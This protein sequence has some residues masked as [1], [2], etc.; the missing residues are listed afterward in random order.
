M[1]FFIQVVKY[2]APVLYTE[3]EELKTECITFSSNEFIALIIMLSA[4]KIK[5]AAN[6]KSLTFLS[7]RIFD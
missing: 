5:D 7:L 6:F 3:F 1:K 4:F 2:F